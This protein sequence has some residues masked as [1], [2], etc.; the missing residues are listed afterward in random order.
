MFAVPRPDIYIYVSGQ[1]LCITYRLCKNSDSLQ[2]LFNLQNKKANKN[3]PGSFSFSY[4]LL[5]LLKSSDSSDF[6]D[7]RR[8]VIIN[9]FFIPNINLTLKFSHLFH[10]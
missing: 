9:F 7:P 8:G 6:S 3:I 4:S 5:E 1:K 10:V 2:F